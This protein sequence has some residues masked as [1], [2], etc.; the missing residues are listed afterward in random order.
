MI[1]LLSEAIVVVACLLLMVL[2]VAVVGV[3]SRSGAW[4]AFA[5]WLGVALAALVVAAHWRQMPLP[6]AVLLLAL[7]LMLWRQR[8]RIVWAVE[9]GRPW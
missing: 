6:A 9:H 4:G 2:S 1:A 3:M 8:G 5:L 7:A